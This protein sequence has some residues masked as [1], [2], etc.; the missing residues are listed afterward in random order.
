[1]DN[2]LDFNGK[3]VIVTGGGKGIGRGISESFLEA[4]ADVLICGRSEPDTLA[5]R[6]R[7]RQPPPHPGSPNPSSS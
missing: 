1:M 6:L 3:S 4:G 7:P 5:V 2:P